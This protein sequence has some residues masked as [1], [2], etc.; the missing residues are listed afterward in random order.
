MWKETRELYEHPLTVRRALGEI[1]ADIISMHL[2]MKDMMLSRSDSERQSIIQEIDIN[3]ADARRQFNILYDRYLGP[4]TDIDKTYKYF[5]QWKSIRDETIRLLRA[6]KSAEAVALTKSFGIGGAHEKA[7]LKALETVSDFSIKRGDKFYADSQ[8]KT[9]NIFTSLAI[10]MVAI[11]LLI[12]GVS[13]ILMNNIRDPLKE[14]TS[15]ADQFRQGKL[16]TRSGYASANEYGM[17]ATAFN[18]LAETIQ[19]E[20]Q[21]RKA[22]ARIAEI[23]LKE[24]DLRAFSQALLKDLLVQTGS[25]IGAIYLLNE[26][27]TDFEHFESIG[28]AAVNHSSFSAL[29][30]EGEF[31]GCAGYPAD[32]AYQGDPG[33]YELQFLHSRR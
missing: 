31:G 19:T 20:V 25:Q 2:G 21:T 15:A 8:R 13:Y 5:V 27:K 26:Q 17:L 30:N 14:L 9:E 22:T 4:R 32:T 1:K 18:A 3:E 24:E 11:F 28:L 6:G 29:M 16:D 12:P 33:G 7:L 23:M 10:L